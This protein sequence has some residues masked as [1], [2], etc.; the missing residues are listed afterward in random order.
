MKSEKRR[1]FTLIELLVVIAIIA[2]LASMLLP[3]LSKAKAKARQISCTS[4][5][6]QVGLGMIMYKGDSS[7]IYPPV[8]DD[9]SGTREIWAEKIA[10]YVG[11]ENAF[12]CPDANL[13]INGNL[14]RTRYQMPMMHVFYEGT[15]GANN[16]VLA[17]RPSSTVMLLESNNCWWQ[18]YCPKHGVGTTATDASTGLLYING[19]LNEHT[20]PRHNKGCNVAWM[21]GHVKWMTIRELASPAVKYWDATMP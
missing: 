18:H 12:Q 20:W 8:Y 10:T 3:A 2:I 21:D 13:P 1:V 19:V 5:L 11:D 6:K 9:L 16:E 17:V 14:Q 7:G 4:N 15:S